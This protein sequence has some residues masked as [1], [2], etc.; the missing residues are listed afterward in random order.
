MSLNIKSETAAFIH[1]LRK[2]YPKAQPKHLRMF[3]KWCEQYDELIKKE[4]DFESKR[5]ALD[6]ISTHD[7]KPVI[8]AELLSRLREK[9]ESLA[10]PVSHA[11]DL[12]TIAKFF[13]L[14][15]DLI[16]NTMDADS[17]GTLS[18]QEFIQLGCPPEYKLP[19]MYTNASRTFR[20]ILEYA[21]NEAQADVQASMTEFNTNAN[22]SGA[23]TLADLNAM[24]KASEVPEQAWSDWQ[25]V[26]QELDRN[27][28]G[29]ITLV[30][31]LKAGDFDADVSGVLM[32]FMDPK[33]EL[34]FTKE[35]FLLT[36]LKAHGYCKRDI[37]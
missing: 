36:M 29:S 7:L 9:F 1:I 13:E 15:V 17:D 11:A 26:F 18:L 6:A 24:S 28:D 22:T 34:S 3:R 33:R 14:D 25:K 32:S 27:G 8:P 5:S 37:L 21:Y 20:A 23:L 12:R 19:G 31:L 10:D 35:T 2:L 30:E 4:Q 16:A